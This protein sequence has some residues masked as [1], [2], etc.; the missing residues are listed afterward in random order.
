MRQLGLRPPVSL[1]PLNK[2]PTLFL[3]RD[4]QYLDCQTPAERLA[5]NIAEFADLVEFVLL[6]RRRVAP[7]GLRKPG[8]GVC[9]VLPVT[10]GGRG[11]DAA[12]DRSVESA[13]EEVVANDTF[14]LARRAIGNRG[15]TGSCSGFRRERAHRIGSRIS[16]LRWASCS[17]N[18]T[19]HRQ[20]GISKGITE[21]K[22]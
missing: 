15:R 11:Q 16:S 13:G 2:P 5:M 17:E 9:S 8:S 19:F 4:R 6:D 14:D 10:G 12:A 20:K 7:C 1:P 21:A 3:V 22:K 18:C